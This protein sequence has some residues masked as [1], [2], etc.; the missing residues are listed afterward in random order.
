MSSTVF[1]L[2]II[3]TNSTHFLSL[4]FFLTFQLLFKKH[5]HSFFITLK[6]ASRRRCRSKIARQFPKVVKREDHRPAQSAQAVSQSVSLLNYVHLSPRLCLLPLLL[7]PPPRC[8]NNKTQ[9][10]RKISRLFATAAANTKH[11]LWRQRMPWKSR[12]LFLQGW[13]PAL[14]SLALRWTVQQSERYFRTTA[15][16]TIKNTLMVVVELWFAVREKESVCGKLSSVFLHSLSFYER[17]E[18]SALIFSFSPLSGVLQSSAV[19]LCCTLCA[20]WQPSFSLLF[21]LDL[22]CCVHSLSFSFGKAKSTLALTFLLL[23]LLLT[24]RCRHRKVSALPLSYSF[25]HARCCFCLWLKKK[26][27]KK[28]LA[29]LFSAALTRSFYYLALNKEGVQWTVDLWFFLLYCITTV[30]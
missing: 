3:I 2:A 1:C 11:S 28:K 26:K 9:R 17:R 5:C 25:K 16:T 29:L 14:V 30:V 22:C 12:L 19:Q 8:R 20:V 27:K 18:D 15:T 23:L 6:E 13:Q 21:S 10:R 7:P 4:P 24:F